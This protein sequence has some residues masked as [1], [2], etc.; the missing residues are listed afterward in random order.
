M[1]RAGQRPESGALSADRVTFHRP[2]DS[3]GEGNVDCG[4]WELDR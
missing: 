4:M 1:H 3:S 2:R